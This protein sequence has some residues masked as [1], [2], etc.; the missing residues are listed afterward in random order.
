MGPQ[1]RWSFVWWRRGGRG[2]SRAQCHELPCLGRASSPRS[3]QTVLSSPSRAPASFPAGERPWPPARLPT[4]QGPPRRRGPSPAAPPPMMS[5]P[6]PPL[7]RPRAPPPPPL[8]PSPL[9]PPAC[10][11]PP[12]ARAPSLGLPLPRER[13]RRR[14]GQGPRPGPG[15]RRAAASAAGR[16]G[17]RAPGGLGRSAAAPAAGA[18]ARGSGRPGAPGHSGVW[19]RLRLLAQRRPCFSAGRASAAVAAAP[20]TTVAA[21]DLHGRSLP[22][23]DG[24]QRPARAPR[25][26]GGEARVGGGRAPRGALAPPPTTA[27]LGSRQSAP[28]GRLRAERVRA[29]LSVCSPELRPRGNPSI[30]PPREGR[31]QRRRPGTGFL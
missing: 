31:G 4:R 25:A 27:A 17:D 9:G 24:N 1:R 23:S 13:R 12:F 29:P 20:A 2:D 22:L 28:L 8:A 5:R 15:E 3:P 19:R 11:S 26:G 10:D 7:G 16:R 18:A 14:D 21:A 30:S 6:W